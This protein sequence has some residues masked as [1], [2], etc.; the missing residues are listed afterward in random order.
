MKL[1]R[2][3]PLVVGSAAAGILANT[4]P[5]HALTWTLNNVT[6]ADGATATG[7]FDYDAVSNTYSNLNITLSSGT[8]YSSSSF[9]TSHINFQQ[10]YRFSVCSN[11]SGCF[12]S[13][14][15][16]LIFSNNLSNLPA[17]VTVLGHSYG[18]TNS[19]GN[20]TISQSLTSGTIS[21][22]AAVPFDI[23]GGATIPSVGALLALGAMRKTRKS[24]ASKTRIANPVTATV[25]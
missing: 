14:Y 5:A 3:L 16:Y 6:F 7:T 22:T 2:I 17:T 15:L 9:N 19:S 4:S 13:Q 8:I 10:N 25:S 21:S 24:I 11:G 23:P 1:F 18:L 12:N 20:I